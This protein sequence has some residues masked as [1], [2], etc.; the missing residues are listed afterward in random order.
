M[1]AVSVGVLI[2]VNAVA[3]RP[4][5]ETVVVVDVNKVEAQVTVFLSYTRSPHIVE[6]YIS[7]VLSI[8]A[9]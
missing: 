2:A 3:A 6:T 1:A 4:V 8:G 5:Y 9:D 7:Y